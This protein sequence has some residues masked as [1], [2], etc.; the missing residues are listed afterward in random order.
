MVKMV[1]EIAGLCHHLNKLY[2]GEENKKIKKEIGRNFDRMT[3]ILDRAIRSRLDEN[4][5]LYRKSVRKIRKAVRDIERESER[6]LRLEDFVSGLTGLGDQL[7]ELL[8]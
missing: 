1:K 2:A 4:D 8:N 3:G 7:E 5:P 6:F